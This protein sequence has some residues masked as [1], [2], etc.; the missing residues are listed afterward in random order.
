MIYRLKKNLALKQGF[1]RKFILYITYLGINVNLGRYLNEEK[2]VA[3]S[4]NNR[5]H[6]PEVQIN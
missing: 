1:H 2:F 5:S 3:I 6:F 4:D